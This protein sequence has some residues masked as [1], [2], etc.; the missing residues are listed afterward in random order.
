[1]SQP[2]QFPPP[3]P[4]GPPYG[5][6]PQYGPPQYGPPPKRSRGLLILIGALGL[7]LVVVIAIGAVVLLRASDDSKPADGKSGARASTRRPPTPGAGRCSPD[8]RSSTPGARECCPADHAT[9][10]PVLR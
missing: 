2:N 9:R 1:M 4:G 8:S 10:R 5:G 6:P 3:P 7:V